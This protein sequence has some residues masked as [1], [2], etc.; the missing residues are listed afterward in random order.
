MNALTLGADDYLQKPFHLAE[1]T[2]RIASLGFKIFNSTII[3]K[4]NSISIDTLAKLV[5][6]NNRPVDLTEIE[7]ELLLF[8]VYNKKKLFRK[9]LLLNIYGEIVWK[10][11]TLLIFTLII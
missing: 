1:L 2:A 7:Y 4:F 11:V 3:I 6:V 9:T 5:F 10:G 8:L